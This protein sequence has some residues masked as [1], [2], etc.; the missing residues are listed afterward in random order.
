MLADIRQPFFFGFVQHAK[1]GVGRGSKPRKP[2][3]FVLR[4][5]GIQVYT[6][7]RQ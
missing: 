7:V 4:Q 2:G 5:N 3:R 6:L 1:E